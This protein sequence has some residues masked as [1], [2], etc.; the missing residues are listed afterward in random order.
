[1]IHRV[2]K[3]TIDCMKDYKKLRNVLLEEQDEMFRLK[4]N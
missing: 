3:Y 1:M 4:W 2:K